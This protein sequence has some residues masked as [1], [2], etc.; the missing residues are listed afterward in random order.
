MMQISTS[1][2]KSL[3][4]MT[5]GTVSAKIRGADKIDGLDVEAV[6]TAAAKSAMKTAVGCMESLAP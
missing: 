2:G 1:P 3:K 5:S 6:V 4:A